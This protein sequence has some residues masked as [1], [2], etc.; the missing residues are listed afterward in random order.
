MPLL[1][2]DAGELVPLGHL[3]SYLIPYVILDR[4]TAGNF[5]RRNGCAWQSAW[6][7]RPFR[8]FALLV[9]AQSGATRL[10]PRLKIVPGPCRDPA[11]EALAWQLE[12]VNLV[13]GGDRKTNPQPPAE[14]SAP[15]LF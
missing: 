3:P 11:M 12:L 1:L 14:P 6:R 7:L 9:E 13:D 5:C 4:L 8:D 10:C 15:E 2:D